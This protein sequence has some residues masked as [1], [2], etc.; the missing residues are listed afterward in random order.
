MLDFADTVRG[1]RE[2]F[3]NLYAQMER[4]GLAAMIYD[5]LKRRPACRADNSRP[6]RTASPQ[7]R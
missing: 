2:Y 6:R 4:G 5:L 1:D 3:R 7:P